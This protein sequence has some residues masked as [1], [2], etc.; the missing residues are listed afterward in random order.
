MPRTEQTF[1]LS[2]KDLTDLRA[3]ERFTIALGGQAVVL[4]YERERSNGSNGGSSRSSSPDPEPRVV[5]RPV[6][7][8]ARAW[9]PERRAKFQSAMAERRAN[10]GLRPKGFA[11]NIPPSLGNVFTVRAVMDAF[12]VADAQA[13]G[14]IQR[15]VRAGKVKTLPRVS[16]TEPI[17]YGRVTLLVGKGGNHGR[18]DDPEY[19]RKQSEAQHRRWL[20]KRAAATTAGAQ[21]ATTA[22]GEPK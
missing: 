5:A 8:H 1:W 11:D 3:G 6:N 4:A 14:I 17:P 20:E 16:Q 22:D 2:N 7:N 19:R 18:Y 10:G 21:P 13:R 15:W 9:T 12:G